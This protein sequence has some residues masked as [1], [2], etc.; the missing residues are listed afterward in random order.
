MISSIIFTLFVNN[1]D[2]KFFFNLTSRKILVEII[3][4]EDPSENVKSI[5]F[6]SSTPKRL[7]YFS[8]KQ[9]CS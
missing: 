4:L 2:S 1:L 9:I 8:I 5:L 3:G 7:K 6:P